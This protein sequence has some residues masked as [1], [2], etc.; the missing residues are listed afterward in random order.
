MSKP[1][2]INVTEEIVLGLVRFLLHSPGYQT[3][4]DCEYCQ[5]AIC[6]VALN[7]LPTYY[8]STSDAREEAYLTLKTQ[9]NL[10]VINKKIIAAIHEVGKKANHTI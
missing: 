4:C 1:I 9:E 8:V 2:L 7:N 5:M 3:F 10:E 6:S